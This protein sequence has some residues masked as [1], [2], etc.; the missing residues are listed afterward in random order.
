MHGL[1][2]VEAQKLLE[3]YGRNELSEKRASLFLKITKRLISPISLML[4]LAAVLSFASGK[5]F[6]GYFITFLIVVNIGI[7]LWQEGKADNAIEKLKENFQTSVR[8]LRDGKWEMISSK[9]V[10]P[11]DTIMLEIGN[12]VSA[13]VTIIEGTNF[14]VNEAAVT[15]ES[16]P[17][18]KENGAG[19]YSGAFVVTGRATAAV[20]ATGKS[21]YFGKTLKESE[22]VVKKSILEKDI[23]RISFFLSALSLLAVLILSLALW[24]AGAPF[25][26]IL[27]LDLSLVIA[28][29]P[30]SLPTVMT[31]IISL[32]VLELAKKNAVVRRISSLEDLANVNLL[33]SDKTG[34][35]TKNLV[36]I[37]R[38]IPYGISED[39]VLRM[40]YLVAEEED[41]DP[42][43]EAI[44]MK[45]KE[46]RIDLSGYV[47]REFI[48]ADSI[49]KRSTLFVVRG[50]EHMR[51]EVGAPQV[52]LELSNKDISETF[53][54]DIEQAAEGGFRVLAVAVSH[55]NDI[56]G[57]STVIGLLLL[58]DELRVDTKST[59]DFLSEQGVAV[60]M[61]TGDHRA[62]AERVGNDVGILPERIY[63]EVL[64][65]EKFQLVTSAK[66]AGYIVASTGDG[67]ND[68]PALKAADVGIAV[69]NAVDALKSSADIVL[70]ESGLGV[71]KDAIIESRKIFQRLWTYSVYRIAESF[72]II[73]TIAVLGLIYH[74]Y[75]LMPVQLILLAL[76]ND[77]PIIA[78][79]YDRVKLAARP[80]HIDVKRRIVRSSLFGFVGVVNSLLMFYILTHFATLDWGVI[81]TIFFLKLTISGHLLIYIAHTDDR[82]W[83]FLPSKQV[84]I[85]TTTT[86]LLGT[87]FAALGIFMAKVPLGWILFVWAWALFWMQVGEWTKRFGNHSLQNE[88]FPVF[89]LPQIP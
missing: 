34:T 18:E 89:T 1:T 50:D 87:L 71:I 5:Q 21:T 59:L 16:L 13:D 39:E 43:N 11:G 31:L 19:V 46:Q 62:I 72:R 86:Q 55:G 24:W 7:T 10:V 74:T 28:G 48:P 29:I 17:I 12:I 52:V 2:H 88:N 42:L 22:N 36:G 32:G 6:D 56:E 37:E 76:L 67:I 70:T 15:G 58:S 40:A 4:L 53:L 84:I 3:Q 81:Q 54:H 47:R 41:G 49:R 85:A 33:L 38:V 77:L 61:V 8:T 68:L 69:S 63:A 80:A 23:L 35:L 75:P 26:D 60:A 65:S 83:K 64:P 57:L 14:S 45:A 82:W 73:I 30:I 9:L 20:K 25:L 66:A 27:T 51:I 44:R 78:L 79:S